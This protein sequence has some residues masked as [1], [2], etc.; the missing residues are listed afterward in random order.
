MRAA[1]MN[2]TAV[3]EL[4]RERIDWRFKG[5]PPE[6]FGSTIEQFLEKR[7]TLHTSGFVGPLLLLDRAALDHNLRTMA[8]WCARNGVLLCPHGKT[9]MAPQLFQRQL[10]HGA[11]GLTAAN[12]S[13]LR[14]YRAFGVSRVLL[15]N[16]LVDPSGLTWV[17]E[18]LGRDPEFRFGCWVDSPENVRIM[19]EHLSAVECRV[20]VDVLVEVGG[21]GG[22][23]GVRGVEQALEVARAARD[24]PHLRLVGV[25][26]Y[27]G[28]LAHDLSDSGLAAVD[29][30]LSTMRETVERIA[31]AGLFDETEEIVVTAGGSSYFDQ[32]AEA[33]TASWGLDRPVL[34]VLR[35]GSYVTHDHGLYR[36]MSPFGRAHRLAGPE[37][38]FRPALRI[39]A[40]VT[41]RPEPQL[42]LLTL[43]RR[44]ASFD[45]DLPQ[46]H[47][48]RTAEGE[49]PLRDC[50]VTELADQHA[51]VALP[52]DSGVE[53]GQWM[54]CGLSHPCTVFDKWP[55]I[56]VVEDDE[57]VD[58][59]RTFF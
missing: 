51:F 15:A 3:R 39:L 13:Q 1:T 49:F 37:E 58:L 55:L 44:D 26:G 32:V 53:I 57:V 24:S 7:P 34:A 4:R 38:P 33:L 42:A 46:P 25:S 21:A 14:V 5:M 45:Q 22:R 54:E 47:R 11:W 48:L 43:G 2:R 59:V 17:A 41:S 52:A 18:E 31:R 16:Q 10:D 30:Y 27:E 28:A 6:S 23:T 8:E 35:S 56:P 19:T 20:P 29:R 50:R 9:T 40:Q 36:A 12:T